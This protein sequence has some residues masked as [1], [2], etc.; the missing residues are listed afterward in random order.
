MKES[1]H[2]NKIRDW[3]CELCYSMHTKNSIPRGWIKKDAYFIC[4][5]CIKR[6]ENSGG[7]EKVEM[8]GEYAGTRKNPRL[9]Q[10]A[11]FIHLP[12]CNHDKNTHIKRYNMDWIKIKYKKIEYK[13]LFEISSCNKC[14][15]QREKIL[16][17]KV[18]ETIRNAGKFNC[19][20]IIQYF[21]GAI[22]SPVCIHGR[23]S[24]QYEERKV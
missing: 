19:D 7:L 6:A 4:D 21:V 10:Y 11:G 12:K 16:R 5:K 9:S 17:Q 1:N 24:E 2:T 14:N 3:V 8:S 20:K 18:K 13:A 15:N 23:G 22:N